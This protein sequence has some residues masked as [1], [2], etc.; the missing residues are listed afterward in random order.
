MVKRSME[1]RTILKGSMEQERIPGARG[2]MK[3][4]QENGYNTLL[5]HSTDY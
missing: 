1:L 5:F 3:K 4:E 2:K